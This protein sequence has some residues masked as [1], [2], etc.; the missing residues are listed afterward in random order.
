MKKPRPKK[1]VP[2]LRKAEKML[3]IYFLAH[4]K[5]Q[6][7]QAEASAEV[8]IKMFPDE[9]ATVGML[10]YWSTANSL[11]DWLFAKLEYR[12]PWL[13]QY[14]KEMETSKGVKCLPLI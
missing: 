8:G 13:E 7:E 5:I 2:R 3:L 12:Q 4:V 11:I 9:K 10:K 6:T 1:N 14:R